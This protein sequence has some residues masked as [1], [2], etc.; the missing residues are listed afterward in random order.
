MKYKTED[1]QNFVDINLHLQVGD[2]VTSKKGILLRS[3]VTKEYYLAKKVKVMG[4]G[5]FT[6]LGNKEKIDVSV[7]KK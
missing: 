6:V 3:P 2:T 1:K 4:K 7:V 5:L